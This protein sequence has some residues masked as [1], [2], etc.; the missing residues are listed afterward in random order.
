[1]SRILHPGVFMSNSAI[2]STVSETILFGTLP[3]ISRHPGGSRTAPRP[4]THLKINVSPTGPG[5]EF[6]D[7]AAYPLFRIAKADP[8]SYRINRFLL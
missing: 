3:R 8:I 4:K 5:S 2:L 7:R 6:W 1:M